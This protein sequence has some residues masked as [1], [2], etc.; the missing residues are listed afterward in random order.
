MK[1]KVSIS[2]LIS[3]V[4]FFTA[5]A[6]AITTMLFTLVIIPKRE[7]A[8][9]SANQ[10]LLEI[11]SLVN[12]YYIGD[13][14][15]QYLADCLYS[16]YVFGL[17]DKYAGYITAADSEQNIN[18]LRGLY[19]G[20]GVQIT[21]HPDNKTIYILYIH[22]DSP[23]EE[24]GLLPCDEIVEVDGQKVSEIGYNK[25]VDYISQV[26]SG[27]SL[28][29]LVERQGELIELNP[30]LKQFVSQT[31]FYKMIDNIG[32]ISITQFTDATVE[33]FTNTVDLLVDKGV[34]ALVFDLRGNGG[35]TLTSV[36]K[37]VDYLVPEGL[38]VKLEYK[39]KTRN[40]ALMSDEHCVDVPMA[41]LTDK[42]TASASELFAQSLK[43]YEMA[44]TVG[45]VTYGKGV[46]QTTFD[47]S[48]GSM[49]RFTTAKY[50]TAND[51]C[52]DGVG[53]KPDIATEWNSNELKYRLI[54]GI[55]K[56]KDFL[57][58]Y[59]ALKNQ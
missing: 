52:V 59:E 55:E 38:V 15:E 54:N 3:V 50:Y 23:A 31:V 19:A 39:D 44:F 9:F 20:L 49:I 27:S 30:V 18:D 57:K 13:I 22:K 17:D 35:G 28:K 42:N 7:G 40:Q 4:A 24:I 43:D 51:I 29:L 32:Y 45:S 36:Y 1:R 53:V 14:D 16:G 46:V 47:L 56:D 25:A 33:Q 5:A 58:A 26:A 48:D 11:R 34:E 12:K 37:M 8:L 6:V 2:F 21:E 41:V 10:K